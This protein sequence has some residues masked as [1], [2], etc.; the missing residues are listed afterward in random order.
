MPF[1]QFI[2][3]FI[4]FFFFFSESLKLEPK[5]EDEASKE[6]PKTD[7]NH[8]SAAET[9]GAS[10]S[11]QVS[12]AAS[13]ME[14]TSPGE[15]RRKAVE[16]KSKY[17]I[18]KGE[19][20]P[21]EALRAFKRGKELEKQAQALDLA[22]R[23]N[24]KKSLASSSYTD[25]QSKN[26]SGE[27]LID[28]KEP[29]KKDDLLSELRDL[30]W[31]DGDLNANDQKRENLTLE[32]EL[33]SIMREVLPNS[34]AAKVSISTDN[35]Q[36]LAHKKK[37]LMFKRE[38]KLAEAKEEL[39]MAKV[40]ERELEEQELLAQAGDASDDELSALIHGL[41]DYKQD[42]LPVYGHD[43]P[44]NFDL[45]SLLN[46]VPLDDH[47]DVN[48]DD[49]NDPAMA[50]TL[51]SFGWSDEDVP[52]PSFSSKVSRESEIKHLKKEALKQK[53]AGNMVEAMELL[54]NAKQL[55]K[56]LDSNESEQSS[57]SLSRTQPEPLMET[58]D[59]DLRSKPRPK[60]KFLIQRELLGVKKKALA[61]R[62][63]GRAEEAEEELNKGRDLERQLQEMENTQ[64]IVRSSEKVDDFDKIPNESIVSEEDNVEAVS[65]VTDCDMD[66][67]TMLSALKDLGWKKKKLPPLKSL[68]Q[69][70]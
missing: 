20:K 23:K 40:L 13:E 11:N 26:N 37:A 69:L 68:S 6:I 2:D 38:G 42:D 34:G 55:E 56:A 70:D 47:L 33:S 25:A 48:D 67:P 27:G 39:K 36:V 53:Q 46:D 66:D 7:E 59:S 49:M 35:S 9:N 17:R 50:A 24:R 62:R 22:L 57:V 18:L 32:G 29:A 8:E 51:K 15:L 58:K 30:G 44:K 41:D 16:E 1:S 64:K 45:H 63:E 12:Q 61:L 10:S 5:H 3:I 28:K 43:P 19:G 65:E 54:R 4:H 14:L 31:D 60:S 21:E 52:A